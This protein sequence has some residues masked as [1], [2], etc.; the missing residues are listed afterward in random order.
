[1]KISGRKL[2]S[3]PIKSLPGKTVYPRAPTGDFITRNLFAD[4]V[5]P[6]KA[7]DK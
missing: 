5:A 4:K 7:D 6:G 1:V 2:E 3:W